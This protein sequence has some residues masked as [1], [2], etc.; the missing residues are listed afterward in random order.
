AGGAILS[1]A[2]Q[3]VPWVYRAVSVLAEQVAN[4]PFR[5][6]VGA[7]GGENLITDGPLVDFYSRPHP[8]MNRFQYW[9]LRV[10][11][12]MLRGECFRVPLYEENGSDSRNRKLKRILMP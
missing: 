4:V 3:Q 12:L 10:L 5:F 11:W 6:S 8:R 1:N 2:Y 9:E 7:A